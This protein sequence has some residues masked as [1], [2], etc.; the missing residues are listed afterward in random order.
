MEELISLIQQGGFVMIPILFCSLLGVTIIIERFFALRTR[1]LIPGEM[2]KLIGDFSLEKKDAFLARCTQ[3]R[4]NPLAVI[5]KVI[6]QNSDLSH[7]EG[8]EL[9]RATGRQETVS[10]DRGLFLLELIAAITPLLGL[11]GTVLGMIDIFDTI[12]Q[13][14]VGQAEA[15]SAG[16]SKALITTVAGLTVA[17]PALAAHSLFSRKVDGIVAAMDR[18]VTLLHGKIYGIEVER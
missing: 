4:K 6:V 3:Y 2:V 10:L 1:R 5:S 12:S 8:V 16:I 7:H 15:L 13:I 17:I 11:L 18:H 14:G 9:L